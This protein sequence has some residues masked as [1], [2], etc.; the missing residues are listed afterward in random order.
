M[1]TSEA[2]EILLVG[3]VLL[4]LGHLGLVGDAHLTEEHLAQLTCRI[5][6][7]HR[8]I[9]LPAYLIL[10]ALQLGVKLHAILRQLPCINLHA[11]KLH[12]RQH[13]NH[14]LLDLTVEL[15]QT[16]LHNL[17]P[18]HLLELHCDVGIL[19]GV[20]LNSLNI[21]LIHRQLTRS[22]AYKALNGDWGV[23]EVTLRQKVHIMTRLGIQQIV[24]NHSVNLLAAHLNAQTREHHHIELYVLCDLCNCL[25]FK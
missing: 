17:C 8:L 15:H 10:K 3:A 4:G 13:I 6:I 14:R 20:L 19:G 5:D 2:L 24:Q 21:N 25:I 11:R 16:L 9:S 12:S 7:E 18:E 23:V 1:F 22:L